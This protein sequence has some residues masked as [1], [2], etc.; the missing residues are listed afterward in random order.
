MRQGTFALSQAIFTISLSILKAGPVYIAAQHDRAFR[1]GVPVTQPQSAC[2]RCGAKLSGRFCSECGTP[3]GGGGPCP[4]CHA[5]I[6]AGAKF[7]PN[8]GRAPGAPAP[9]APTNLLPYI[10]G[11]VALVAVLAALF[12]RE[13][14]TPAGGPAAD[15]GLGAPAAPGTP[16]DIS[17]L[18]PR[19]RFDRLYNR[20]MEASERG[21]GATVTQFSPMALQAY[22]MLGQYDDDARYHAAMIN[23]GTG[24]L[25]A[26][27][28]LAD[29]ILAG[30]P[31]HLLGWVI[32]GAVAKQ[33]QDKTGI[34]GARKAF[35]AHYDA[36]WKKGLSEYQDH[37]QI[38][39]NYKAEATA[40]Q[41][42][43]P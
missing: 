10:L 8:C 36:E 14:G 6:P 5:A 33:Q 41:G 31:D 2:S 7:C 43:K 35:L 19:E 28:A 25:A 4:S 32:R 42:G 21:D 16:P 27:A 13:S 1:K 17:N 11:G 23:F 24:N 22:G 29:T 34:A 38:L 3:A 9:K 15:P 40:G 26:A 18:S 37:R 39:D 12:L 30:N 20:V